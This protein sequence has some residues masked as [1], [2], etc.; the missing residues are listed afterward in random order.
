MACE[1]ESSLST[2]LF[3][4]LQ[5]VLFV[6]VGNKGNRCSSVFGEVTGFITPYKWYM[7]HIYGDYQCPQPLVMVKK[8]ETETE[9]KQK[10]TTDRNCYTIPATA[11]WSLL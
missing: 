7:C 3:W 10:A 1:V 6:V 9:T 2:I 11:S 5:H 4:F 8:N